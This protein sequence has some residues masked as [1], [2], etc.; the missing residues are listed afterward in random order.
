[1]NV[2]TGTE[3]PIFLFWEYLFQ[4][5]GI[6]SLQCNMFVPRFFY[7]RQ[8]RLIYFAT[9]LVFV[10]KY[11]KNDIAQMFNDLITKIIPHPIN[12]AH[13]VQNVQ[14]AHHAHQVQSFVLSLR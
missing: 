8:Y 12:V 7:L 5:F 11:P 4:I 10:Y 14:S 3:A 1:M 2:E 9:F 6:L 13:L